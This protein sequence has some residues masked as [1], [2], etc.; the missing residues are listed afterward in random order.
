VKERINQA[1]G[2][3]SQKMFTAQQKARYGLTRAGKLFFA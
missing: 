3:D 1:F 2:I